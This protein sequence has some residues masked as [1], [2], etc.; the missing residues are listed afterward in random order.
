MTNIP[1]LHAIP[2]LP[3]RFK[4][5]KWWHIPLWVGEIALVI[6]SFHGT[7]FTDLTLTDVIE[8][9]QNVF[10]LLMDMF[11]PSAN[12][13]NDTALAVLQTF[14]MSM[15]GTVFGVLVSLPLGVFAAK[16]LAPNQS[17]YYLSRGV[18]SFCRTVPDMVWAIFFVIIVGL[19]PLAGAL[20]LFVDTV[21]FAG[22]FFGEAMEEIDPAPGEALSALGG[23]RLGIVFSNVIPA[24]FPS[25]VNTSL[26]S[27]ERAV[28]S[29]VVLGLVGAGGIGMLLE[30]PMTWHNY[31]EALT[32][33]LCIF[34][35]LVI[36]EQVSSRIRKHIVGGEKTMN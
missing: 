13:L 14:Q 4:R 9:P 25:F 10:R 5:P 18:I 21:G 26:F 27:L 31:D 33:V 6:H 24:A 2:H 11:P 17:F 22:R 32:V 35:M 19:G 3:P 16:N 1:P 34:L 29:S 23:T 20:T 30:E 28:Q 36:V 15:I 12:P 7:E 8:I